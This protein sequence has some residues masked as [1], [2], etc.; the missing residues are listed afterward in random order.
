MMKQPERIRPAMVY[1]NRSLFGPDTVRKAL[2]VVVILSVALQ[3]LGTAATNGEPST[4]RLIPIPH[5]ITSLLRSGRIHRELRLAP[6]TVAQIEKAVDEVDLPLWRLRDLPPEKRNEQAEQL[7]SQLRRRL[8]EILSVRQTDRLNQIVWQA[9]GIEALL[10][11]EVATQLRLSAEQIGNMVAL[12]NTGYKRIAELRLNPQIR[13]ESGRL[14]HIQQVRAE[15]RQ[16]IM[17]V[18]SVFQQNA[19]TT[20][21]GQPI[22]LSQ[23]RSVACKAPEIEVETWINSSPPRLSGLGGKVTVVHFYAFGCGNCIRSLPYYNDWLK[24]FD[25]DTFGI[26]GIHRPET[27]RERDAE[28][29]K[30]KAAQASMEYPIAIDNESVAWNAWGNHTWPT[31][32]LIDKNSYVRYWWYGELNWQGNESE[33]YLRDRIQELT[34][35]SAGN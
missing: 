26:V 10:E 25:A 31:T 29:V 7:V 12:L 16:N 6:E 24:R 32:Y 23:V 3:T 34:D 22:S 35:E 33:K 20:L 19:L 9:Q 21:M 27:E 2:S 14:A 5:P 15:A 18:L 30:E 28:K 11:P 17:A 13:A 4:Q 8:S 1:S